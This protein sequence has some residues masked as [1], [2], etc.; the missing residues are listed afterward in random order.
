MVLI[1]KIV[2]HMA[3]GV[4]L[5][6]GL[7]PA[8]QAGNAVSAAS[9][10][11]ADKSDRSQGGHTSD[12]RKDGHSIAGKTIKGTVLRVE[13]DTVFVKGQDGKEVRMHV[14]NTTQM[15]KDIERGEP[16]E[17]KVNDQN[18]ALSILS[19]PAVTDRRNDKE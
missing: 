8:A 2:G 17:A 6:L 11:N 14:D 1:T 5:C 12:K 19:G 16:I 7:S 4:L 9:E 13:G 18:H 10:L 15:G 3:C